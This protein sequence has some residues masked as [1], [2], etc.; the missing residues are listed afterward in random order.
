MTFN[1]KNNNLSSLLCSQ[2]CA[3]LY[4]P[5]PVFRLFCLQLAPWRNCDV[6]AKGVYMGHALVSLQGAPPPSQRCYTASVTVHPSHHPLHYTS[7]HPSWFPPTRHSSSH[8]CNDWKFSA[9]DFY[10]WNNTAEMLWWRKQQTP[11]P[12]RACLKQHYI[13]AVWTYLNISKSDP[14]TAIFKTQTSLP[15][16]PGV[17]RVL[18]P[19]P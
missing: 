12:A 4:W 19:A 5:P 3:G 14:R 7:Q 10:H 16:V 13:S 18:I 11:R 8:L 17:S 9:E 6:G 1:N 15:E 2:I